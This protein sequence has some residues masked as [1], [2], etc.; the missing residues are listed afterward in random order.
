MGRYSSS[1]NAGAMQGSDLLVGCLHEQRLRNRARLHAFGDERP[2][3]GCCVMAHQLR[4]LRRAQA[5]SVELNRTRTV[6]DAVI[7]AM[8]RR[9]NNFQVGRVVVRRIAVLMVDL[10]VVPHARDQPMLIA[11]DV[12]A[13]T[14]APP[15]TDIARRVAESTWLSIGYRLVRS[16]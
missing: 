3:D 15:E 12:F 16:E 10:A 7:C 2:I 5:R 9:R 13:R 6:D 1:G 4:D 11:L 14:D 8:L